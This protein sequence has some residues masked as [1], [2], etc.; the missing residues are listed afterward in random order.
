[1]FGCICVLTILYYS[2]AGTSQWEHTKVSERRVIPYDIRIADN[3]YLVVVIVNNMPEKNRFDLESE[4][5][6]LQIFT[7]GIDNVG[8]HWSV[9]DSRCL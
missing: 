2:K 9:K 3:L 4:N 1:M 7:Y 8:I 5:I 6:H